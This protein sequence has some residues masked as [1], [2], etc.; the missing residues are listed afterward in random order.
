MSLSLT[1]YFSPPF[2]PASVIYPRPGYSYLSVKT[3]IGRV[4]PQLYN[5]PY[6][7]TA[8]QQHLPP[9]RPHQTTADGGE[10]GGCS[11]AT[12]SRGAFFCLLWGRE[13]GRGGSPISPMNYLGG[14]MG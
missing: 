10:G 14:S 1:L 7:R 3:C 6:V 4:D 12:G 2:P 13:G 11:S 5:D 8:S 9:S